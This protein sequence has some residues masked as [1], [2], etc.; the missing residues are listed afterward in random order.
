MI[1]EGGDSSQRIHAAAGARM[2]SSL[3]ALLHHAAAQTARLTGP[4]GRPARLAGPP[5]RTTRTTQLAGLASVPGPARL[6]AH[7]RVTRDDV[8]T[9][10]R[11]TASTGVSSTLQVITDDSLVTSDDSLPPGPP[12]L[13]SS[14]RLTSRDRDTPTSRDRPRDHAVAET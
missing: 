1:A 12:T 5:T 13:T 8:S 4:L 10:D 3:S 14:R 2:T 11:S 9:D 7:S 6:A